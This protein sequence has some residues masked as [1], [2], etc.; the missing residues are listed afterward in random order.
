MSRLSTNLV[1]SGSIIV[2]IAHD[3]GD[4]GIGDYYMIAIVGICLIFR[5]NRQLIV[6]DASRLAQ[7]LWCVCIVTK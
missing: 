2:I 7:F 4:Y 5:G 1:R 3:Y 6:Y